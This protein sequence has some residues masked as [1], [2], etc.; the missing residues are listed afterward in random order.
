MRF[1]FV[2]INS[3]KIHCLNPLRKKGR[4]LMESKQ[5]LLSWSLSES[6]WES[7]QRSLS[8]PLSVVE[9]GVEAT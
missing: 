2:R 8:W 9:V 6:R 7:K 3:F 5:R 1:F 4:S